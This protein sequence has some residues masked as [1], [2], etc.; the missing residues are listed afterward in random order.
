MSY[1]TDSTLAST[2]T[3]QTQVQMSIVKAAIAIANGAKTTD[4]TIDNKRGG[5]ASRVLLAP[6]SWVT[7]FAYACVETGLTGTPTDAQ[8][9]VAVASVWNGMAGV[10]P[11]D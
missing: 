5:L 4:N 1:A 3:F 6:T 11:S 8:V 2:G 10:L 7:P 9:D